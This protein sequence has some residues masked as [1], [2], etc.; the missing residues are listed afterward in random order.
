VTT[1]TDEANVPALVFNRVLLLPPDIGGAAVHDR[2]VVGDVE[3]G[4][5]GDGLECAASHLTALGTE[6]RIEAHRRHGITP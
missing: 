4:D 6:Q 1:V 2:A 5:A 3:L